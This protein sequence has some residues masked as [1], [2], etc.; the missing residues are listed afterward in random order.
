MTERE[1]SSQVI[2]CWQFTTNFDLRAAN[3]HDYEADVFD[4]V[5]LTIE[6]HGIVFVDREYLIP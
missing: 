2:R 4:R 3:V 5:P 1:R 6:C